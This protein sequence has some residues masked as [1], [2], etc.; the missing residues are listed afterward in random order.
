MMLQSPSFAGSQT[1]SDERSDCDA[2]ATSGAHPTGDHDL[3]SY[4]VTL[5]PHHQLLGGTSLTAV[6]ARANL[7]N[8]RNT[9][10][11]LGTGWVGA[12]SDTRLRVSA[13]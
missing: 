8:F 9:T 7:S 4:V 6:Y 2:Q 1:V 11:G 12:C 5:Y 3:R 10:P 13:S